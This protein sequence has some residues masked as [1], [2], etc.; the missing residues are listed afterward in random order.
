[1]KNNGIREMALPSNTAH[2]EFMTVSMIANR[3]WDNP[4]MHLYEWLRILRLHTIPIQNNLASTSAWRLRT[5][6]FYQ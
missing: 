3:L 6:P 2:L 4:N 1:M 5:S